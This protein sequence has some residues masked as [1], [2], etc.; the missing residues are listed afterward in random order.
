MLL[1]SLT[2]VS[3]DWNQPGW[4]FIISKLWKIN[5]LSSPLSFQEFSTLWMNN[6]VPPPP[7]F[8]LAV[9]TLNPHVSN[10]WL[11]FCD[12]LEKTDFRR[13][14]QA[15]PDNVPS[16]KSIVPVQHNQILGVKSTVLTVLEI[17][18]V[19]YTRGEGNFVGHLG[20]LP[21]TRTFH[22]DKITNSSRHSK[23]KCVCI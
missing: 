22:N 16:S 5:L 19:I 14:S 4:V 1:S 17:T 21:A 8:L 15:Y 7:F 9:S 3:Q 20:I 2:R 12:Q 13:L 11:P 18:Q 23:T 6:Q 10:F